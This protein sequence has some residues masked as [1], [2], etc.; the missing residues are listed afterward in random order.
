ME[1]EIDAIFIV[2]HKSFEEIQKEYK[3]KLLEEEIKRIAKLTADFLYAKK[4]NSF[5][6]LLGC[7]VEIG[8]K[9]GL[10]GKNLGYFVYDILRTSIFYF[11]A[12]E[13]IEKE[14]KESS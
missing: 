8:Y 4:E 3:I 6:E 5:K 2:P 9:K 11:K 14:E 13:F 10:K 12:L 1:D 7:I